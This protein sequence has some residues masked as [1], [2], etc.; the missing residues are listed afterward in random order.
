MRYVKNIWIVYKKANSLKENFRNLY[1]KY[2]LIFI[3]G[4]DIMTTIK[5]KKRRIYMDCKTG[6]LNLSYDITFQDVSIIVKKHESKSFFY[7][8]LRRID[9][10]F[11]YITSG[12]GV[13]SD[14]ENGEIRIAEG[15]LLILEQNSTY[16][17]R[18]DGE[19]FS[20]ITTAFHVTPTNIFRTMKI[21]VHIAFGNVSVWNRYFDRLLKI[22]QAR[23]QFYMI[24]TKIVLNE[25]MLEVLKYCSN[26][27]SSSKGRITAAIEYINKNCSEKISIEELAR[28]CA[29]SPSYFR[30]LFTE[31]MGM[32]PIKYRD[33]IRIDKAKSLLASE[34]FNVTEVAEE[35]GFCDIYHFSK[36]FKKYTG[37]SPLEYK[38]QIFGR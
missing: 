19:N 15:S 33:V 31:E 10:G 12:N 32:S 21:P 36:E 35:L 2:C 6:I 16:D 27:D 20:Y 23:S 14:S 28:L 13:Y 37:I 7:K 38:K 24:E 5:F 22:W 8:S 25:I 29:M 30:K 3:R 26:K 34:L 4:Y 11:I 17:I 9:Y 1:R 18:A